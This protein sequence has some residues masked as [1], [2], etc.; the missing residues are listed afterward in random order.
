LKRS[1]DFLKEYPIDLRN[2]DMHNSTRLDIELI[3]KN[4]RG[5]TTIERLPLGEL[6]I[7]RH[8]GQIFTLDSAGDGNVLFSAGDTWLMPY[9]MGRYL[10]V[11]SGAGKR[12]N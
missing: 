12:K 11:I 10:G 8:N 4:F 1:I 7:F 9:W 5:Q 2:W 6:P 3:P